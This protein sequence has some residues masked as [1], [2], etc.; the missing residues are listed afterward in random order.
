MD[1]K[2]LE[3][4]KQAIN[5]GLSRRFDKISSS[6]TDEIVCSEGHELAMRSIV[7]GKAS[8]KRALSLTVQI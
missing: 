1:N 7:Y 8:E 3:L 4:F 6:F 5:E 2:N